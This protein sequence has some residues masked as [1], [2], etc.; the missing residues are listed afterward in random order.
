MALTHCKECN[1][2]VS[3]EAKT[4]PFCG[5]DYP[6][7]I[8]NNHR[9]AGV[10]V[11]GLMIVLGIYLMTRYEKVGY[12]DTES[13][14][15]RVNKYPDEAEVVQDVHTITSSPLDQ[16][17]PVDAPAKKDSTPSQQP[18]VSILEQ[19]FVTQAPAKQHALE[20]A[21]KIQAISTADT[22]QVLVLRMLDYAMNEGGLNHEAEIQQTKR[23]LE[24]LPRPELG[25]KKAAKAINARGLALS[26]QEDFNN[27]VKMFEEANKL[28]R[29]DLE[30]VN[31]LGYA[32]LKT[33]HLDSAQHLLTVALTLSPGRATAWENLGEVFG[34]KGD[35]RKAVACFANAYRFSK[36]RFKMHRYMKKL[37]EKE[38]VKRL[39]QSRANAISWAEQTYLKNSKNTE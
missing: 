30:I 10:V 23:L 33:G 11:L 14:G 15:I 1:Q 28:D 31:N 4:C 2:E 26:K 8:D 25:N 36:D 34:A 12:P 3:S 20:P 32:Y 7:S 29:S 24:S 9:L 27:A 16:S 38:Q 22:P 6:G 13:T 37:N 35:I 18:A 19:S 17:K 5:I 39:K 21:D